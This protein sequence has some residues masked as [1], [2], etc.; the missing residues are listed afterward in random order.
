MALSSTYGSAAG[1][2]DDLKGLGILLVEDSWHIGCAMKNLLQLMG[3]DVAG[4][5]ATTAEAERLLSERSPDVAIV[6]ISLREGEQAFGLIDR[7]H[8]QGVRV[9]VISGYSELPPDSRAVATLQKPVSEA[10]LLATLRPLI[11]Q[12]AAG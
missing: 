5:A 11:G 12:K 6:D 1:G 7:L 4:P 10:E 8:D 3:A 2:S 9:V